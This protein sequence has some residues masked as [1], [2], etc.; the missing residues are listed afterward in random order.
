MHGKGNGSLEKRF[1]FLLIAYS[2]M[3]PTDRYFIDS[4]SSQELQ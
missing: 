4:G 3:C 1:A 2:L